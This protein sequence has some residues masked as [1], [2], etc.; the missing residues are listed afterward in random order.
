MVFHKFW[1]ESWVSSCMVTVVLGNLLSCVK[2]V[3][4]ERGIARGAAV[5][6]SLILPS[7]SISL[8]ISSCGR[9]LGVSLEL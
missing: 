3:K 6:K 7:G 1:R 4:S 8:F 2:G 5:E 9:K